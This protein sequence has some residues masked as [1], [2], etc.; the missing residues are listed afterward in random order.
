M[1]LKKGRIKYALFYG[2]VEGIFF[3]QKY[4]S[5]PILEVKSIHTEGNQLYRGCLVGFLP[6]FIG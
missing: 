4:L 5:L 6:A 1:K 2:T 3:R